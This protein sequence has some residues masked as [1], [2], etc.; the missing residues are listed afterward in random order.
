MVTPLLAA[1]IDRMILRRSWG[2]VLRSAGPWLLAVIP[3]SIVAKLVQPSAG[4]PTAPLWQRPV[5]AGASLA[6][7]LW[8]LLAP[9]R[10]SFD[11][12][13]RPP[14]M[15]AKPWFWGIALIPVALAAL[16]WAG[17]RRWPWLAASALISV[18]ALLPVL[19]F[20]PF[21]YQY[22]STVADH[23][24]YVAMLGPAMV[25]AW[26][27]GRVTSRGRRSAATVTAFVLISLSVLS[28]HEL[29]YWRTEEA[30][31]HR[32]LSIDPDSFLGHNGLG[33]FYRRRGDRRAE[34][35]LRRALAI[36]PDYLAAW[37]NL[38]QVYYSQ[39]RVDDAIGAVRAL[40]AIH[41]RLP[42]RYRG[43][44][45]GTLLTFGVQSITQGRFAQGA[46]YLE[47]YLK[48]HPADEQARLLLEK[49]LT[50]AAK[51]ATQPATAAAT[52]RGSP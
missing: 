28:I 51:V 18:A 46:T 47:E 26:G 1:L 48:S 22:Y 44:P 41:L 32:T 36:D 34:A 24:A 10:F 50:A 35:E 11:Y 4:I 8:K 39:G 49:A 16:I 21:L 38:A 6:F 30:L 27:L 42:E 13:W 14:L 7:Y 33:R 31:L 43:D 25:A 9:A 40:E 29:G 3:L 19:G 15:L 17:R 2:Q 45:A 37:E 23:Y 5:V 12:G 20:T 52:T